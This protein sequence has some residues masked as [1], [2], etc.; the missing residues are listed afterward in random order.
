MPR[1][2]PRRGIVGVRL[3]DEQRKTTEER[4]RAAGYVKSDG[5]VNLSDQIRAD[6][7]YAN[8]LNAVREIVAPRADGRGVLTGL[9]DLHCD[10]C[11]EVHTLALAAYY[12]SPE[13]AFQYE[14]TYCPRR[15]E[16]VQGTVRPPAQA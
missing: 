5:E 9:V 6:L 11:D 13:D 7:D 1:T 2:G 16:I 12:L 15:R 8:A 10:R 3:S 4:G 14:A